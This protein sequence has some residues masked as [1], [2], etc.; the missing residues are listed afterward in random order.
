MEAALALLWALCF[1]RFA[2]N[3]AHG[4]LIAAE[5]AVFCFLALGLLVMDAETMLLPDAFTLPG[6]AL[7]LLAAALPGG[8]LP[9]AL[10][11][12]ASTPAPLPLVQPLLSCVAGSLGAACCLLL[13]RGVYRLLR[14]REGMGLGDVKLA[15]MIGAWLGI[16]GAALSLV[17]G[18]LLGGLLAVLLVC[19]QS[20]RE[21]AWKGLR[22]PFGTAL[23][24][25]ALGSLLIGQPVLQWYFHFWR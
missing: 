17:L 2:A 15:A 7:G 6:T 13:L 20:A 23:A 12:A 10:N 1:A 25:G 18:I 11:L 16:T 3:P 21:E 19:F 9:R 24:A 5:A 22:V 8:G 14:R 4:L